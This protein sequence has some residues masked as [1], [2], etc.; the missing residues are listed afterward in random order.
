MI[1][2]EIDEGAPAEFRLAVESLRA[3]EVRDEL[4][5][6]QI[7][8]PGKLAKHEVAFSANIDAASTDVATDLGT[9]RF[10]LLWD[11]EEPEPWGSRFRV[12]TFAKSPLET[13]IG[14]DEQIADVAWAWLTEALQNRHANFI[15]EAGTATRIIS[16]GYGALSNQSDHAELEIRAS[17]SPVDTNANAHLEAWQDLVCIMSGLPNLPAGVS[18]L[19]SG[20]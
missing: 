12:I 4:V 5:L 2:V 11:P 17:W 9:G 19:T 6:Q 18:S 10:V 14:A 1:D 16:S 20:R 7:D 13:D 3:A 15:A 8:A